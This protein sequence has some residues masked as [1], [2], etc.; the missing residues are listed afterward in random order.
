MEAIDRRFVLIAD[1]GERLYPYKKSQRKTGR[2]GFAITKPGEQD[3]DGQGTY[4]EDL[5]EVIHRVVNEGWG[6]R[7]KT[8]DKPGRQREGTLG[9]N[10]RSVHG[11][12]INEEFE[13]LVK[14]AKKKPLTISRKTRTPASEAVSHGEASE[15]GT[16]NPVDE[17]TYRAIKTRR[18]QPE[19]R[20]ALL[21]SF[22]GRC[23]ITGCSVE[24]VLE[25]AHIVPHADETNYSVLNGLLLRSDMHTLF[26]LNLLGIDGSG[27]VSVSPALRESEYWEYNGKIMLGTIPKGMSENLSR[28]FSMYAENS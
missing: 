18:G 19:F 26:D 3:R 22:E 27:K 28:R 2:Y 10:K 16:E 24:G 21:S 11:Y 15:T 13:H 12:E 4:T 5:G 6:V 20:K 7:V 8:V 9:V 17:V 1:N 14:S 23:C 25:A